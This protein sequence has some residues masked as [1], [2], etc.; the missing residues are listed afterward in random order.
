M[1]ATIGSNGE[2]E[3]ERGVAAYT[4]VIGVHQLRQTFYMGVLRLMIEP[5]RAYAGVRFSRHP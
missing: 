1:D 2:V 3:Q 4:F 5:P